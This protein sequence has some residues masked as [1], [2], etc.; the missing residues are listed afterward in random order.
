MFAWM[1]LMGRVGSG[2]TGSHQA[3]PPK[4]APTFT[5]V[6]LHGG[7]CIAPVDKGTCNRYVDLDKPNGYL[8]WEHDREAFPVHKTVN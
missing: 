7:M 1:T 2:T 3:K 6:H 5:E 4:K 8:C